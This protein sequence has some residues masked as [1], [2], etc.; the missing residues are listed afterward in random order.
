MNPESDGPR[1]SAR[2]W[3]RTASVQTQANKRRERLPKGS[4]VWPTAVMI[5]VVGTIDTLVL[6]LAS[7]VGAGQGTQRHQPRHE[8]RVGGCF[9]GSNQLLHPVEA[10]EVVPRLRRGFAKRLHELPPARKGSPGG[11]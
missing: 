11:P 2:L 6:K 9:T 8:T 5:R 7:R 4:P 1:T 10:G 3:V